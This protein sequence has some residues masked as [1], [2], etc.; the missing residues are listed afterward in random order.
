MKLYAYKYEDGK[1][2][3]AE[4]EVEEKAVLVP[5]ERG[6][7]PFIYEEQIYRENVGEAI[8]YHPSI[9]L[10]TP[11]F[12]YAKGKLLENKRK[13]LAEKE[14][15]SE[16]FQKSVES[17]KEEIKVLEQTSEETK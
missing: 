15:A 16:R 17:L 2:E 11:D 10:K 14:D 4:V 13:E 5:K 1:I 9:F 3:Q 8:G 7:L 6:K 12:E